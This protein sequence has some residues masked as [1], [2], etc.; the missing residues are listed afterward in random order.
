MFT[1]PEVCAAAL[2]GPESTVDVDG[3]VCGTPLSSA[4]CGCVGSDRL[5]GLVGAAI[6]RLAERRPMSGRYGVV[7][8]LGGIWAEAMTLADFGFT[9]G[10]GITSPIALTV[11]TPLRSASSSFTSVL[12]CSGLVVAN[13]EPDR[14]SW[15]SESD[16][17]AIYRPITRRKT[18]SRSLRVP[19]KRPIFRI[20]STRI[21]CTRIS[22]FLAP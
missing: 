20:A 22:G 1:G 12:G 6:A 13:G 7:V 10:F 2:V 8:G 11:S 17:V 15:P 3:L 21:P 18:A 9:R 14:A 16:S 5:A 4:P 19:L